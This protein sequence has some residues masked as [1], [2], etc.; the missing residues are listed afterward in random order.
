M[1]RPEDASQA[2]PTLCLLTEEL[3]SELLTHGADADVDSRGL[4]H[5]VTGSWL[6]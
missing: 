6:P 3:G 1:T 4:Q 2:P 5:H